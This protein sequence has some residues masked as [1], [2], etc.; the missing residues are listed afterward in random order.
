MIYRTPV[1]LVI[2]KHGYLQKFM[3]VYGLDYTK[4]NKYG[5]SYQVEKFI[6]LFI[7]K[8]FA[9]SKGVANFIFVQEFAKPIKWK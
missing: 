2:T 7:T 6:Q 9:V 8:N 5:L 3:D 1:P 4:I